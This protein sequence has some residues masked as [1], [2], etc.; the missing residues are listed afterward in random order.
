VRIK[1][2]NIYNKICESHVKVTF[3][4]IYANPGIRTYKEWL[5]ATGDSATYFVA[6]EPG[7]RISNFLA[8][9]HLLCRGLLT[10]FLAVNLIRV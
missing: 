2:S 3:K 9:H 6:V 7:H 5:C 1:I 10:E 8:N 4:R